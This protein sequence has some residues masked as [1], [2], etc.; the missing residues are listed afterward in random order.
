MEE[1]TQNQDVHRLT[2]GD[3]E[4]I[5]VGTAHVSRESADLVRQVIE[6]EQPDHVCVE[7]DEQRYQAL[8]Q[9]KQWES[10][11]LRQ[12][13]KNKQLTT[14]LMNLL[15][16]SYQKRIGSK[17]GVMP[18]TELLE[19]VKTAE[20]AGIPY[21]LSD[22]NVRTTLLRAWRSM[23]LWQRAKMFSGLLAGTFAGEEITEE[24]LRE[25]RQK[26][27]LTEVMQELAEVMPTLKS[28]LIDERDAFLAQKI[29]EAEGKRI[30]AVVG[31]GHV[32]G[33]LER[34]K[35]GAPA[36]ME[37]ITHIPQAA[38]VGKIIGWA[39]PAIIIGSL[40]II[41]W[42]KGSEVA[43]ENLKFWILSNGVPAGLGAIAALAHPLTILT[44][45]LAAPLT[46]LTP[47]IG[48]GYVTAFVQAWV[49]PPRV[50]DFQNVSEEASKIGAWWRNRLL[51]VLLAFIFPTLGSLIGTYV[52][53]AEIVSNLF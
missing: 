16:S 28:V 25:L 21:S 48:A 9:Q 20:A 12:I 35:S 33:M 49:S 19:A 52:G 47:V 13:I 42:T 24:Q 43:G 36:D 6:E 3:R 10:L 4:F 31:A 2:L 50:R 37:R 5:L 40:G 30:V 1:Q 26:D 18:G 27:V 17:L 15:L 8:S 51:R 41:F 22:R 39:I 29:R 53:G 14:L 46:S 11:D 44:A 45:F 23:S 34:L 38:P 7:L 32:E